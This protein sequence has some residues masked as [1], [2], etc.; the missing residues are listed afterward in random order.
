M[1]GASAAPSQ[2]HSGD[3]LFLLVLDGRLDLASRTLGSHTLDTGDACV[4]PPG[5]DYALESRSPA[6]VLEVAMPQRDW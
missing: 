6:E 5:A 2:I 3:F 4:I 1:S